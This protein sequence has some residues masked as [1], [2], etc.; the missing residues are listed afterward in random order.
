MQEGEERNAAFGLCRGPT[1][2]VISAVRSVIIQQRRLRGCELR[3]RQKGREAR[4]VLWRSGGNMESG[5]TSS[6]CIVYIYAVVKE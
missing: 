2:A 1:A 5:Y 4:E 6:G 3:K